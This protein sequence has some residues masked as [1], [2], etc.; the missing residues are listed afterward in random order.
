MS[1]RRKF[2]ARRRRGLALP[3]PPTP[4]CLHLPESQ[5]LRVKARSFEVVRPANSVSSSQ[6][7]NE[8]GGTQLCNGPI[9]SCTHYTTQCRLLRPRHTARFPKAWFLLLLCRHLPSRR[10]L[11]QANSRTLPTERPLAASWRE[12]LHVDA[13]GE[14]PWS[15]SSILH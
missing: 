4:R 3:R 13:L 9:F 5:T 7:R 8:L 15:S 14:S 2:P 1:D 12:A 11:Q 6:L 10:Q